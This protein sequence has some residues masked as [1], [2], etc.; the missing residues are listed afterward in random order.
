MADYPLSFPL[1]TKTQ[2]ITFTSET[3]QG[4]LVYMDFSSEANG[5][6][7]QVSHDGTTFASYNILTYLSSTG[8]VA[9]PALP[10]GGSYML[11]PVYNGNYQTSGSAFLWIPGAGIKAVQLTLGQLGNS[12]DAFVVSAF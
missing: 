12:G 7:I 3:T 6:D 10:N 9:S 5:F 11:T 2:E 4:M 1:S 8:N